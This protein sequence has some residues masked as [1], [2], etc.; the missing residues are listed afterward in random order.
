MFLLSARDCIK[1]NGN[2][3]FMTEETSLPVMLDV[4]KGEVRYMPISIKPDRIA[5]VDLAVKIGS[6]CFTRY[7]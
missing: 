4:E 5:P 6:F 7:S 3:V 2:L 1:Y